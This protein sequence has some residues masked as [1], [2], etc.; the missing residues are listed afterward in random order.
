MN[1]TNNNIFETYFMKPLLQILNFFIFKNVLL[2]K[3]IKIL[4]IFL[5]L[6]L[7]DK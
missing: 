3:I 7:Q 5:C 6:L 1:K 4:A 2:E